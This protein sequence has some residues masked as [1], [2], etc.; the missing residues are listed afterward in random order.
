[1]IQ[2]VSDIQ[3]S[4]IDLTRLVQSKMVGWLVF[5]ALSAQIGYIILTFSNISFRPG[6]NI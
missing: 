1:M 5:T 2:F 6:A 3:V 4:Y